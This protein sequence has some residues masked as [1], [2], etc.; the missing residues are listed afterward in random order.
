MAGVMALI[1]GNQEAEC[2]SG[3]DWTGGIALIGLEK[4]V[5]RRKAPQTE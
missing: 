3:E 2:F 5:S 1:W 4:L